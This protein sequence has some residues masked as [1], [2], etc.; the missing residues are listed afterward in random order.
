MRTTIIIVCL[1]LAYL[2]GFAQKD[3][4]VQGKIKA[5]ED[6]ATLMFLRSDGRSLETD[7]SL[8]AIH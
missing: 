3:C 4:I 2:F 5:V 7:S 6:G 1:L 8:F